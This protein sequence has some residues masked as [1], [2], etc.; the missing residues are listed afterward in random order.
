MSSVLSFAS[1][2]LRSRGPALRRAAASSSRLRPRS[3]V[4]AV[5]APFAAAP[6]AALFPGAP[7]AFGGD[8]QRRSIYMIPNLSKAKFQK[9]HKG[10]LRSI[11][12]RK[13]FVAFGG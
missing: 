8:G 3:W 4:P 1:S 2:A 10:R 9:A 5:A 13:N 7:S 12:T 11:E 6:G